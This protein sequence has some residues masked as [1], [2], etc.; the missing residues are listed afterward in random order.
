MISIQKIALSGIVHLAFVFAFAQN[1]SDSPEDSSKNNEKNR[2]EK[3]I[4]KS[5]TTER[6]NGTEIIIDGFLDDEAWSSVD[7]GGDF[8]GYIPEFDVEPSQETQFKILY[9]DKFIYVGIR[10]FDTEPEKIVKRMSRRDGF[11]GDFVEINIDSYNDKRTAFSFSACVSG[12]KG[13]EYVSNN[14]NNW[15]PTWDPIWYLKTSIDDQGWIAEFKIP[16]SQLRFANK[17]H[18]AWGIQVTRRFFRKEERSTW[19]PIDPNAPGWVHL[20]G[21]LNGISGIKPQKQLEIMP[22]VVGSTSKFPR[23]DGNP[24]KE[25]GKDSELNAGLDAKI[26][27]TSDITL[28]LTVNPDFG[29]VEAD[30]SQ[31]NLSALELFFRERRPFFLEGNNVLSFHL[32]GGANNLFYSRRIGAG[33]HGSG[34]YDSD[35]EYVERNTPTRILGAAKLTGK[36]ANGFSWGLLDAVTGRV[37]AEITDSE[38]SKREEKVEPFTNFTVARV[39]QDLDDGN[40][41]I[42]AIASNVKRFG[43]N[44]NGLDMLHNSAQSGGIDLQQNFVDRKYSLNVSFA[45]TRVEGSEDAITETQESSRRFYQRPDNNYR[46]VNENRTTLIGT[47]GNINFGRISGRL[48]WRA[49]ANYR[50]PG[51]EANDIGFLNKADDINVWVGSQY[52]VQEPKGIF[53]WQRYSL[54]IERNYDFGGTVTNQG[55]GGS[56]RFQFKNYWG[57]GSSM[58][59]DIVKVDNARLRGGPAFKSVGGINWRMWMETNSQKKV[60]VR[61]NP[62]FYKANENAAWIYGLSGGVTIRPADALRIQI[63]PGFESRRSNLQYVNEAEYNDETAYILG[64]INQ[65]TYSA[66]VRLNYNVT[67]NLTLEFWG[68]PFMYSNDFRNYKRITDATADKLED[69]YIVLSTDQIS[70]SDG[71]YYVDEN[72]GGS[73]YNFENYFEES[74]VEFKSNFVVRWEYIPG[75]TL[76]LVWSNNGSYS[77][78]FD[79]NGFGQLKSELGD[80][81]GINTFLIKYTYRFI[82]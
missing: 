79:R 12:V 4:T 69:R 7:W 46:D 36:N 26:G 51:F 58:W 25:T 60:R 32:S 52:R 1:N 21:E 27:I 53:R 13:D 11:D 67:P 50:S 43:I 35:T 41:V 33:Y 40:T 76:F 66:S 75:S 72:D 16:L 6:L 71:I 56:T 18:H 45:S 49:G 31:V 15:D 17:D 30:P 28:D 70:Y 59:F 20:F 63:N 5:Y 77:D 65:Q 73:N 78:K 74:G 47:F 44:S 24:Y 48:N 82:L 57:F 62:W 81:R 42:G 23:E 64:E 10:A 19:Q 3:A 2:N 8:V 29:Q 80:L 39:Q 22:Y 9:D 14:G 54:N 34:F 68:Q 55:I 37:M 38:G 61:F